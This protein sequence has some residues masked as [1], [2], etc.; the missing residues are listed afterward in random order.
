[1]IKNA[2]KAIVNC[3]KDTSYISGKWVDGTF[4]A[5]D[6]HHIFQKHKK[7]SRPKTLNQT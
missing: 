7:I 1:M 6:P 3:T 4:D 5:I 2:L